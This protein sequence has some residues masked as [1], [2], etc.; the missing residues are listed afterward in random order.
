MIPSSTQ[1][2]LALS[3]AALFGL[4]GCE[5]QAA[6][7]VQETGASAASEAE[8]PIPVMGPERHILAF[9]DSLFAGYGVGRENSYPA[10]LQAALRAR[11]INADIVNAGISGDTTAAGLARLSYTLDAQETVPELVILELGGNDLLRSLPPA[12]T[13]KNLDAMMAELQQRGI[14]VLLM[15]MRAP[16]NLGPAFQGEFD[17]IYSE[18]AEEYDADL[19]PFFLD[20]IYRRPDLIQADRVHPTEEGISE[21]V[22]ATVE[23]VVQALPPPREAADAS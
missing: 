11:G 6:A 4:A 21:L 12:E 8:A 23:D 10:Q 5:D 17:A 16:P 9:G 14:P 18:L 13:R 3:A 1:F 7:P 22:S 15:G 2:A 20:S 19:V